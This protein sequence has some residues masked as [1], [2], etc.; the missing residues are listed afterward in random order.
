MH[1][2]IVKLLDGLSSFEQ[3]RTKM[4]I[5]RGLSR[6]YAKREEQKRVLTQNREYA[7]TTCV[8]EITGSEKNIYKEARSQKP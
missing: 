4:Q 1:Y 6:I 8:D 2:L 7:E 3:G 5:I